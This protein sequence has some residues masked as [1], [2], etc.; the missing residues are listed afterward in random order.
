MRNAGIKIL[1]ALITMMLLFTSFIPAA[2]AEVLTGYEAYDPDQAIA[3]AKKH[4][5]DGKGLCA[6][7]VSRCVI[8]G[9]IQFTKAS[10]KTKS[11][12]KSGIYSGCWGLYKD[13][14]SRPFVTVSV[15]KDT[16]GRFLWSANSG[17][18][19][20]GDIV[21]F[22]AKAD[23]SNGQYKHVVLVSGDKN[24]DTIKYYAHNKARD[25]HR[26]LVPQ[27]GYEMVVI[28]F[29]GYNEY[30]TYYATHGWV[31]TTNGTALKTYPCSEKTYAKSKTVEVLEPGTEIEV[32]RLVRNDRGNYWYEII[33]DGKRGR[34]L[35]AGNAKWL[36]WDGSDITVR[37]VEL[38]KGTVKAGK[39]AAVKGTVKSKYNQMSLIS[40]AVYGGGNVS[41]KALLSA[42]TKLKGKT[43]VSIGKT[44]LG[45]LRTSDLGA[46]G[47]YTFAVRVRCDYA[48]ADGNRLTQKCSEAYLVTTSAFKVQ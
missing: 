22:H 34:Y 13:L 16:K 7:F 30:N 32:V 41:G 2:S 24:K 37:D 40:G 14:S 15:L 9:G 25:G 47:E 11:L 8:S 10:D 39:N 21:F 45:N 23:K 27:S 33:R 28:H 18:V 42:D 48:Y 35:Y 17:K 36:S 38:P 5:N 12:T 26:N 20:P 6:T 31:R 3:Y 29:K 44:D 1:T 4:W 19:A 43:S 46:C